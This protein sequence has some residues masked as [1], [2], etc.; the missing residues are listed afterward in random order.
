MAWYSRALLPL[1]LLL[2]CAL[3]QSSYGSRSPPGQPQKAEVLLRPLQPRGGV[4][5]GTPSTKLGA[6]GRRGVDGDGAG[7][8]PEQRDGRAVV[9]PVLRTAASP[10]VA[11]RVLQG[12]VAA[13]STAKSS[14]RSHDASVTCPPSGAAQT[15]G[16]DGRRT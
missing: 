9:Q 10:K 14:C 8:G 4:D 6:N 11:R 13:D 3:V 2:A 16:R 7:A 12:G 1:L 15:H 5:D